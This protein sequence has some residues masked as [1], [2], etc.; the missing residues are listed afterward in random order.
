M[1]VAHGPGPVITDPGSSVKLEITNNV[2]SVVIQYSHTNFEL[3]RYS[4]P[5]KECLIA[6]VVQF[7]TVDLSEALEAQDRLAYRYKATIPHYLSGRDNC[8]CIKVRC[9]DISIP[10]SLKVMSER[11]AKEG[12]SPSYKVGRKTITIYCNHF[13]DVICTSTKKIC[14]SKILALPFGR[15]YPESFN[16][17]THTKLKIYVCSFLYGDKNLKAVSLS[18]IL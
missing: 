11:K 14:T 13:C 12:K 5:K 9:G 2:K 8:S 7:H 4:I 1:S 17:Q 18:T 10:N 6:P 15:I 16:V 3:I